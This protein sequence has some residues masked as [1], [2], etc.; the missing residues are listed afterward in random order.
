MD[1]IK[2]LDLSVLQ[3][4]AEPKKATP[5]SQ[6]PVKASEQFEG[7]LV[8]QL[9]DSMWQTVPKGELLSG[10]QEEGLY[11]DMLN[12]AVATSISE[13]RGIGVKEVILRDI[14]KLSKNK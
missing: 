6:D 9:L 14:N 12:E 1:A 10:S 13:G 2:S 5:A 8:K 11:R 7:M 4:V 3:R